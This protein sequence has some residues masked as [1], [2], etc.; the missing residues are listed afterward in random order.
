M[1]NYEHYKKWFDEN[2]KELLLRGF[3]LRDGK[4]G[5]CKSREC[6]NCDFWESGGFCNKPTTEWLDQ[7]IKEPE[8]DWSKVKVDARI[9]VSADGMNWIKR[10]FAKYEH[11]T[12]Y[13]WTGR[14]TS[15][16]EPLGETTGWDYAKHAEE[17]DNEK[18]R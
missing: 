5:F 11:G 14:A 6:E 17:N 3:A 8:T 13:A 4:P 9:L 15:W 1:T 10:H 18:L 7:E 12:V 2:K 16:S